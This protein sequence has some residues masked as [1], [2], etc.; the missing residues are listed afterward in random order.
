MNDDL[1]KL[2]YTDPYSLLVITTHGNIDIDLSKFLKHGVKLSQNLAQAYAE[3]TS[4][5]KRIIVKTVIPKGFYYDRSIEHY[6]TIEVNEFFGVIK[7]LSGV[8][9]KQKSGEIS[10]ETNLSALVAR[11]G[12]EPLFPE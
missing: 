1:N 6:R 4:N 11:R 12:I 7:R 8:Y 3:G 9:E 2:K 10:L 5:T